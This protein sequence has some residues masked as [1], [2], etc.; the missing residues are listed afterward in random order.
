MSQNTAKL[1]AM[2][3]GSGAG[4]VGSRKKRTPYEGVRL[5]PPAN[6]AG[7]ACFKMSSLP[8]GRW[9]TNCNQNARDRHRS[10]K[11]YRCP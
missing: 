2:Q 10:T 3:I 1:I 7:V 11:S 9:F 5:S 4:E 8:V 6:A